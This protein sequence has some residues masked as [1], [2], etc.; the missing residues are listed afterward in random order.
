[1]NLHKSK[2]IGT[3]LIEKEV[4][5]QHCIDEALA[6]QKQCGSKLGEILLSKGK[7]TH[8]D[9]SEAIAKQYHVQHINLNQDPGDASLLESDDIDVYFRYMLI[10]WKIK[11]GI[12]TVVTSDYSSKTYQW[13]KRRYGNIKLAIASRKDIEQVLRK[14]FHSIDEK[15]IQ[16]ELFI[17]YPHYS[18]KYVIRRKSK[19]LWLLL[20]FA[21][22]LVSLFYV[23]DIML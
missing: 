5:H 12:T 10:P 15:K 20:M 14:R 7:I 3:I 2:P 16:D 13:A 19:L 22:F 1:M 6:Q 9:I 8:H 17:K 18:A 11:N 4:A 21:C 23:P